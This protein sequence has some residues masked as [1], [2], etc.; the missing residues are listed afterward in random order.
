MIEERYVSF[1]T[2]KLLKEKG[3]DEKCC[4]RYYNDWLSHETKLENIAIKHYG[5][6][7]L[8]N[9]SLESYNGA[10]WEYISAPT[11]QMAMDW[12][13]ENKKLHVFIE[14]ID[15]IEVGYIYIAKI[16]NLKTWEEIKIDDYDYR[17]GE[18]CDTAIKYCL[19][20]LIED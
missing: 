18:M 4:Y 15:L 19:T 7:R 8:N 17:L 9:T 3:F 2:A 11:Q 6:E 1:E 10:H 13:I 14:C 20:N 12:L 5:T 16:L